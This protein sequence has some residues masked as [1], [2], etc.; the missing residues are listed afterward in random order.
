M[1]SPWKHNHTLSHPLTLGER[2]SVWQELGSSCSMYNGI[3]PGGSP[4]VGG[5][6]I[7]DLET[8]QAMP[9]PARSTLR[10]LSLLSLCLSYTYIAYNNLACNIMR[11]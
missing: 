5:V 2:V 7:D 10:N 11:C 4:L 1:D 9:K 6:L 8:L 3:S